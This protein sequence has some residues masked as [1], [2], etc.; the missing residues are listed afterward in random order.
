MLKIWKSRAIDELT[1]KGNIFRPLYWNGISDTA[2]VV[3]HIV[4]GI[5]SFDTIN[6]IQGNILKYRSINGFIDSVKKE[7]TL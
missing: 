7:V 2:H 6:F 5:I 4:C 1:F 3:A